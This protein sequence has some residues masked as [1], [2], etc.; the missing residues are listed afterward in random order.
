[1]QDVIRQGYY[2]SLEAFFS[3]FCCCL[4]LLFAA[5]FSGVHLPVNEIALTSE[6]QIHKL[7][8]IIK[9]LDQRLGLEDR[10]RIKWDVKR[11]SCGQM[12]FS[13]KAT[14]QQMFLLPS[15]RTDSRLDLLS[16][17]TL[18]LLELLVLGKKLLT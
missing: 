18:K 13:S 2:L 17:Q 10:S 3:F 6:A 7:Q 14:S 16:Q 12:G 11:E 9:E 15:W 5:R 1:M 4:I 8:V